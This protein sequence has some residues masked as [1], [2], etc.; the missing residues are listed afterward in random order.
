MLAVR[1]QCSLDDPTPWI[2]LALM[3]AAWRSPQRL[4]VEHGHY[5]APMTGLVFLLVAQVCGAVPLAPVW[6]TDPSLLVW[7]IPIVYVAWLIVVLAGR[8]KDVQP[9]RATPEMLEQDGN[10]HLVIVRYRPTIF[11][12]VNGYTTGRTST[13]LKWFG[14]A[15]WTRAQS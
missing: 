6:E 15:R 12:V 10:R 2:L 11:C 1:L 8:A 13:A 7:A 14:H 4:C 5:T 9:E 3:T